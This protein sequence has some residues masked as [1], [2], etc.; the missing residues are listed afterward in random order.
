MQDLKPTFEHYYP[1]GV[2]GGQCGIFAHRLVEFPL[3]GDTIETKKAAVKKFG[4]LGPMCQ[5][6][7][8]LVLDVGT[9][10]G[11]IT[12]INA[13][14]GL[15][16]QLTESNIH[17]DERVHHTRLIPK[18]SSQ[19]YGFF[20]GALKVKPITNMIQRILVMHNNVDD[21]A[22]VKTIAE[23]VKAAI[24][25]ATGG[26]IEVELDYF[27]SQALFSSVSEKTSGGFTSTFV[28]PDG[29]AGE[30]AV[31]EQQLGKK[32]MFVCLFYDKTKVSGTQPDTPVHS[33]TVFGSGYTIFQ[34]PKQAYETMPAGGTPGEVFMF[35]EL[36]HGWYF[37]IN[38]S[39]DPDIQDMVHPTEQSMLGYKG[40][41]QTLKPY[42]PM[43][44]VVEGNIMAQIKTQ[45]KGASR[46][47]ILEAGSVTEWQ[48]LCKVFGKDPSLVEE[49]VIN[50]G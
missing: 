47:I 45:G 27:K 11:H 31:A 16:W 33:P 26:V 1:D 12:I 48:S 8:V 39:V 25:E 3:V 32:F 34:I 35:H 46:R 19:I 6:G 13:D 36:L 23:K 2:K 29:I 14:K 24:G 49:D 20:R 41:V 21:L 30:A 50:K 9:K 28:S 4:K 10:A 15:F 40:L 7:D 44:A 43:L 37:R 38:R 5:V 42:W 17:L 22:Q 18:T